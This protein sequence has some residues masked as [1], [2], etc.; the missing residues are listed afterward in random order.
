MRTIQQTLVTLT[1][2]ILAVATASAT[3]GDTVRSIPLTTHHP[4]GLTFDGDYLWLADH[5]TDYLYQIDPDNGE[6]RDSIKAPAYHV[7]G[8]TFD[9]TWIWCVDPEEEAIFAINPRTRIVER[10]IW[11]PASKPNGLAFDGD[12]LWIADDA[13]N[14]LLQINTE[15]GTTINSLKAPTSLPVGLTYD[16]AYLWVSDRYRDKI[17][18]V[19]PS[20]GDVI[21]TFDAPAAH[22]WGLAYDGKYLWNVDY[23]TDRIY[24]IVVQD[25]TKFSR[26]DKKE[27]QCTFIHQVRNFGPDSV[28][29]LDVYLAIPDDMNNQ[30]LLAEPVFDPKPDEVIQDKWGQKVA[31]FRFADMAA[32]DFTNVTMTNHVRLFANRYFILPEKVGALDDI[33]SDIVKAYTV[34]D[35]KFDYEHPT[36]QSALETAVGDESNPYWIARKI[37]NYLIEKLEYELVGGW[38][39]APTVLERGTGSC[40]EYTFVYIAM[41]RAAGVPAR[42]VGSVVI[43]GDDASQDQVFHRWVE[44][45]LPGYEW[46]PVDPSGGDSDWPAERAENFGY[47]S[48]R[49]LITTSGGGGSE[50]LEWSYNANERWT[51]KGRCK[52]DA[53]NFGEW[54][55][56]DLAEPGHK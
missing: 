54:T 40:S 22:S 12:L 46:V 17:F 30:E 45:Y 38:N 43:R 20:S 52:I 7:R 47:L 55:P 42:Y 4:H 51:S 3:P 14:E 37:Y 33:P 19:H 34:N 44:V 10:T 26:I 41:C 53:E 5:L 48:N 50:Y 1:L 56:I 36:I 39:V 49:F 27:Q 24:Q 23:E 2:V 32:G 35:A 18:M 25:K 21:F 15:D 28:K 11:C 16:G 29:S 8:L 6:V 31:H 9:G 13:N